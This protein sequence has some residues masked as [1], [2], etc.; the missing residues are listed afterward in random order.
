MKWN[1]KEVK[2]KHKTFGELIVGDRF[3]MYE[4]D[5][6]RILFVEIE[7]INSHSHG[8][9]NFN[10]GFSDIASELSYENKDGHYPISTS[11]EKIREIYPDT[12]WCKVLDI[13]DRWS[14]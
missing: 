14:E 1:V 12:K 10:G 8:L 4:Y 7:K 9:V 11:L 13:K 5:E 2:V 6:N 3:Y